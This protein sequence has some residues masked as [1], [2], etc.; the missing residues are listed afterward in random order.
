MNTK[1]AVV[2]IFEHIDECPDSMKS[3]RDK[4]AKYDESIRSVDKQ[5]I[6]AEAVIRTL[7]PKREQLIGA[8]NA[9][10][11]IAADMIPEDK[12]EEWSLKY[13]ELRDGAE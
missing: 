8:A 11:E 6:D 7:T 13:D 10:I 3:M 1:K 2:Y 4:F 5:L 9:V 12:V